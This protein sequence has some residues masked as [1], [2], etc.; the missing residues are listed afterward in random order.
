V[1]AG[2][3]GSRNPLQMLRRFGCWSTTYDNW[4]MTA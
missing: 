1:R 2:S 3:T 4:M